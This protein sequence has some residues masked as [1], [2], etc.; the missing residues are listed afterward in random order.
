MPETSSERTQTMK[1]YP[2]HRPASLNLTF[3]Y[4]KSDSEG[5]EI[6]L[7]SEI[8]SLKT[9]L[10]SKIRIKGINSEH[11]PINLII[12]IITNKNHLIIF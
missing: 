8:T 2:N 7:F 10:S 6:V 3:S 12:N 1:L 9:S 4:R 11:I 5:F